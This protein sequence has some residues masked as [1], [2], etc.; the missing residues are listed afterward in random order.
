MPSSQ[1]WVPRAAYPRI[2]KFCA[3]LLTTSATADY[4]LYSRYDSGNPPQVTMT[5]ADSIGCTRAPD[6]TW[7]MIQCINVTAFFKQWYTNDQCTQGMQYNHTESVSAGRVCVHD[8]SHYPAIP[9]WGVPGGD[10][11]QSYDYDFGEECGSLHPTVVETTRAGCFVPSFGKSI[12][13]ECKND[14]DATEYIYPYSE[15][16]TGSSYA[17]AKPGACTTTSLGFWRQACLTLPNRITDVTP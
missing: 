13:V 4:L 8:S 15:D 7:S 3:V 10:Y 2:L 14:E 11:L 17:A 6:G 16:C 1:G 12:R 9:G 5:T